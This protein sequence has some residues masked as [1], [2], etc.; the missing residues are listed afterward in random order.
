MPSKLV[1]SWQ[2]LVDY[3]KITP[4]YFHI[5]SAY[6][7]K[8]P[9]QFSINVSNEILI[10]NFQRE[11]DVVANVLTKNCYGKQTFMNWRRKTNRNCKGNNFDKYVPDF[12]ISINWFL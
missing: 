9:C 6:Y 5:S 4:H 1:N 7:L 8:R 2:T 12:E 3:E 10:L 11:N